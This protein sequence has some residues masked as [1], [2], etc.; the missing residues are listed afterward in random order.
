MNDL[1]SP[2]M[3]RQML[4]SLALHIKERMGKSSDGLKTYRKLVRTR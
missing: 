2:A 1:M 3:R 4:W